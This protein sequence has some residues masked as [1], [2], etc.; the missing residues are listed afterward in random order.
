L[1][2]APVVSTTGAPGLTALRV[3]VVEDNADSRDA[4]ELALMRH[5][6]L[7]TAAASVADALACYDRTAPDVVISDIGMPGADG[8]ALIR[9]VRAREA[10]SG[11]RAL[12][13]AVTGFAA[14][15]DRNFALDC[16]FDE[17]LAKPI[18]LELLA[19][20]ITTLMT[21]RSAF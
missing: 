14:A 9:A 10:V 15:Q 12:A 17:H 6:A 7:V 19:G 18:D 4:L 11:Q 5:G 20:R 1:P 8:Y 3:L 13:I 16:G 21:A 2:N